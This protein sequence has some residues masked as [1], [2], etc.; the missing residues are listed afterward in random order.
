MGSPEVVSMGM[1]VCFCLPWLVGAHTPLNGFPPTASLCDTRP[2]ASGTDILRGTNNRHPDLPAPGNFEG[3]KTVLSSK[4]AT[5]GGVATGERRTALTTSC[6]PARTLRCDGLY[7][8]LSA[9]NYASGIPGYGYADL[10]ESCNDYP[11]I[12]TNGRAS[13]VMKRRLKFHRAELYQTDK[14][15]AWIACLYKVLLDTDPTFPDL[16]WRLYAV[17]PGR[18]AI[19][20]MLVR[21]LTRNQTELGYETSRGAPTERFVEPVVGGVPTING[22]DIVNPDVVPFRGRLVLQ[23]TPPEAAAKWTIGVSPYCSFLYSDHALTNEHWRDPWDYYTSF[24]NEAYVENADSMELVGE[25]AEDAEAIFYDYVAQAEMLEYAKE[26]G[27]PTFTAFDW[28]SIHSTPPSIIACPPPSYLFFSPEKELDFIWTMHGWGEVE[29]GSGASVH[30]DEEGS[31][32]YYFQ[33]L[34]RWGGGI[35]P[36][37]K[38]VLDEVFYSVRGL[39]EDGTQVVEYGNHTTLHTSL[40]EEEKRVE[41]NEKLKTLQSLRVTAE[42]VKMELEFS[43]L[44]YKRYNV[45]GAGP[46]AQQENHCRETSPDMVHYAIEKTG[47]GQYKDTINQPEFEGEDGPRHRLTCYYDMK[48]TYTKATINNA[49]YKDIA[50][51]EVKVGDS[52]EPLLLR[53]DKGGTDQRDTLMTNKGFWD[54]REQI[55]DAGVD[56][57]HGKKITETHTC[58]ARPDESHM[59]TVATIRDMYSDA[60]VNYD[61]TQMFLDNEARDPFLDTGYQDGVCLSS[62]AF[63]CDL[64]VCN[65]L[66]MERLLSSPIFYDNDNWGWLIGDDQLKNEV[67]F[68]QIKE[69]EI[70]TAEELLAES[71]S[72]EKEEEVSTC[73]GGPTSQLLS[74]VPETSELHAVLSAEEGIESIIGKNTITC[75]R[76]ESI[77]H[78]HTRGFHVV[79]HRYRHGIDPNWKATLVEHEFSVNKYLEDDTT[80]GNFAEA[81]HGYKESVMS[82]PIGN[83]DVIPDRMFF[84]AA[85][86]SPKHQ[87]K[88][89]YQ[90]V[91][92]TPAPFS[93]G[94]VSLPHFFY[95]TR[96][97]T[98]VTWLQKSS[99]RDATDPNRSSTLPPCHIELPEEEFP[100]LQSFIEA[101]P[102]LVFCHTN[103]WTRSDTLTIYD[104]YIQM[105]GV[106]TLTHAEMMGEA[107]IVHPYHDPGVPIAYCIGAPRDCGFSILTTPR[108]IHPIVGYGKIG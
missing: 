71:R 85:Y 61:Y 95:L 46:R 69:Y 92:S 35:P 19:S 14:G 32:V 50:Y 56:N 96:K 88:Y 47:I 93:S 82:P 40:S 18:Y 62:E 105:W 75:P 58:Y 34:T 37:I 24:I 25:A 52:K 98:S 38:S 7:N 77:R 90:N 80:W 91:L 57:E 108:S 99:C 9:P 67:V 68:N 45:A 48:A 97:I 102:T 27:D 101:V 84:V 81:S 65:E 28:S 72:E 76:P 8:V 30:P 70:F 89:A 66:T 5:S 20:K 94:H 54:K 22:P 100:S 16:F 26:N 42:L 55:L 49:L 44:S 73:Y 107:S 53:Y 83:T 2:E 13:A 104:V 60:L 103:A 51:E 79:D 12:T 41:D 11:F 1:L 43:E 33:P 15:T 23:C 29:V 78:S 3:I 63:Q 86:D 17:D 10:P 31:L 21:S 74:Y 87:C 106:N 59:C 64:L 4:S 39:L 6:P 36:H